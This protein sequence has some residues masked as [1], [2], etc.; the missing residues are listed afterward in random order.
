MKQMVCYFMNAGHWH[1]VKYIILYISEELEEDQ[2]VPFMDGDH[3]C[4][5][6]DGAWHGVPPDQ[7]GEQTYIRYDK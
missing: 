6:N 7:F 3:V 2:E 5:H 4:H 1:Y